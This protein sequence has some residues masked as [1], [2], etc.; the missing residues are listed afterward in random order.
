MKRTRARIAVLAAGAV[1]MAATSALVLSGHSANA[2]DQAESNDV[3]V[4]QEEYTLPLEPDAPTNGRDDW[5]KTHHSYPA[6]DLPVPV[7]TP[8]YAMVSGEAVV[9]NDD[10]CGLG[11]RI[12]TAD[13]AEFTYCHFDSHAV[14]SGPVE[15]GDLLGE[16]GNTGNT[17]G[18]HLHLQI[19]TSDGELR[20]PQPLS[21]ALYDGDDPPNHNDLPNSGCVH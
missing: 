19:R 2:D 6:T 7:G 5:A 12:D 18:P 15:V 21:V 14:S 8:S 13:G 20:C 1:A 16:T 4:V 17:T 10:S 3:D 9:F 11:V